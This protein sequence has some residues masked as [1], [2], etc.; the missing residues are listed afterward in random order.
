[1][2][3]VAQTDILQERR[4]AMAGVKRVVA[5]LAPRTE[6]PADRGLHRIGVVPDREIADVEEKGHGVGIVALPQH[7]QLLL[8]YL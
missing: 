7:P 1:M 2:V 3:R 5:A 8:V 6:R 4:A